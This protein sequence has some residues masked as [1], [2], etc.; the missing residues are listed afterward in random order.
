MAD[1]NFC[2]HGAYVLA[3]G[4]GGGWEKDKRVN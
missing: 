3:A 2:P 4:G 1:E